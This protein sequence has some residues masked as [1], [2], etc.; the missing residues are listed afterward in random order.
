MDTAIGAAT[1]VEAS[2]AITQGA[3]TAQETAQ[4]PE[5]K[6]YLDQVKAE[7]R[8]NPVLNSFSGVNEMAEKLLELTSKGEP[9]YFKDEMS[10]EEFQAYS[11]AAG[12]PEDPSAYGEGVPAEALMKAGINPAQAKILGAELDKIN[13]Q[14]AEQQKAAQMEKMKVDGAKVLDKLMEEFGEDWDGKKIQLNKGLSFLSKEV[15]NAI[16]SSPIGNSEALL[17]DLIKLGEKLGEHRMIDNV[18]GQGA[19]TGDAWAFE[20]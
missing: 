3:E 7:Y 12:I 17:R 8:D 11:K 6:A 5:R 14:T 2:T 1:Q 13:R 18:F 10:E 20:D 4:A 16:A 15:Q 19:E 9:V